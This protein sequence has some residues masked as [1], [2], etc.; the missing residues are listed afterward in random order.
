[1]LHVKPGVK[2]T[3]LRPVL[4]DI[5]MALNDISLILQ[6]DIT[7]TSGSEGTH[8]AGSK[9]YT[10]EAIDIRTKDLTDDQRQRLWFALKQHL[11]PHYDVVEEFNPPH[12]HIEYDP[13][14]KK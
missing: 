8:M 12:I 14:P 5:F 7:I 3:T 10:G 2:F 11:G 13:K 6:H 9:H 1:M 4:V